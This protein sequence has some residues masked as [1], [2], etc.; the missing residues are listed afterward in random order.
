[1][2]YPEGWIVNRREWHFY[3]SYYQRYHRKLAWNDYDSMVLQIK[4][5][6]ALFIKNRGPK[7]AEYLVRVKRPRKGFTKVFVVFDRTTDS[8]I[9]ALPP[10]ISHRRLQLQRKEKCSSRP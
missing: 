9:T 8:L 3:S 10:T 5:G 7:A 1:M 2:N 6:I 4:N